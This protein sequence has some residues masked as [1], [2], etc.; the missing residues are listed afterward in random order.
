MIA[1]NPHL[2]CGHPLPEGEEFLGLRRVPGEQV[3][4]GYSLNRKFFAQ[5]TK[6]APG[7]CGPRGLNE[8]LCMRVR[9]QISHG[10]RDKRGKIKPPKITN[11]PLHDSIMVSKGVRVKGKFVEVTRVGCIRPI[12]IGFFCGEIVN[13]RIEENFVGWAG[14][15]RD[16]SPGKQTTAFKEERRWH[17]SKLS[18][19]EW[20]T[21]LGLADRLGIPV[22]ELLTEDVRFHGDGVGGARV[23]AG[24]GAD[25]R[26]SDWRWPGRNG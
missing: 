15:G 22:R 7:T 2:A 11:Q 10:P 23:G 16:G 9:L 17:G 8:V 4:R 26:R 24:G 13:R 14:V 20:E 18:E 5:P 21:F 1:I 6:K 19:Q 3:P 12:Y 25:R